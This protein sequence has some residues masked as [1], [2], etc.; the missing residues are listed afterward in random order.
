MTKN[1]VFP[2]SHLTHRQY[3]NQNG[4]IVNRF[5][6][7]HSHTHTHII[8]QHKPPNSFTYRKWY[9]NKNVYHF[10]LNNTVWLARARKFFLLHKITLIGWI[11][12]DNNSNNNRS[13]QKIAGVFFLLNI[14]II[15]G[16]FTDL[17]SKLD[18]LYS[19]LYHDGNKKKLTI[20]VTQNTGRR[21]K[22]RKTVL[23]WLF[24]SSR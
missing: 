21:E 9:S 19:N 17:K 20:F 1:K 11:G 13:Q 10:L 2:T 16:L 4:I 5:P 18:R 24:Y 15:K 8:A 12:S 7:P 22:L 23:K 6:T 3:L 14:E